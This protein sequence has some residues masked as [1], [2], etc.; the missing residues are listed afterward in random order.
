[1]K[2][3]G[4]NGWGQGANRD[5][6]CWWRR[7]RARRDGR[8]KRRGGSFSWRGRAD[9]RNRSL[10]LA[11]RRAFPRW[12][13]RALPRW[14]RGGLARWPRVEVR[15][16]RWRQE[17][18]QRLRRWR[19]GEPVAPG[20]RLSLIF[21]RTADRN[22]RRHLLWPGSGRRIRPCLFEARRSGSHDVAVAAGF[23]PDADRSPAGHAG[24]PHQ[25]AVG[26]GLRIVS[27]AA[28]GALRDHRAAP[29]AI[30]ASPRPMAVL[31]ARLWRALDRSAPEPSR[32]AA[33]PRARRRSR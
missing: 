30:M 25:A 31:R 19:G 1:M 17:G 11:R 33:R 7:R 22:R 13:K 20:D 26:R 14:R 4:D 24:D 29:Q 21:W 32:P 15:C 27:G 9:G 6:R 16:R 5:R 8:A 28:A 23:R 3:V 10:T 12:R 2:R 18:R